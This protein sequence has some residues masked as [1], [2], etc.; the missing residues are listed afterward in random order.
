MSKDLKSSV[1]LQI[2]Y[3]R[4]LQYVAELVNC[5]YSVK[6]SNQNSTWKVWEVMLW[7]K[8]II[9]FSKADHS[10]HYHLELH[11]NAKKDSKK[12]WSYS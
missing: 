8:Q 11:D 12:I 7:Q 2:Q 5:K 10:A 6:H 3:I 1:F 9:L 4:I